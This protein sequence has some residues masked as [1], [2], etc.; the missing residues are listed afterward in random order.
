MKSIYNIPALSTD[1]IFNF[2]LGIYK[3]VVI[4]NK[5]SKIIY[6]KYPKL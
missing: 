4:N 3:D 1:P 5:I 2:G 6:E